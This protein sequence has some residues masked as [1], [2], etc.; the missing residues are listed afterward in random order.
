[1]RTSATIREATA[2]DV[3]AI[4]K[5]LADERPRDGRPENLSLERVPGRRHLLVLD[6]PDGALAA[7]ALVSIEKKRG[8]LA[9]LVVARRFHD[10]GIEDRMIGVATA[11]CAA[12]GADT[13]DIPIRR[14][15]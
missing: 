11:L 9:M 3:P 1:M 12:F 8:H 14:A 6:A 15:A 10:Q 7:A 2:R 4:E 13:I 5:L